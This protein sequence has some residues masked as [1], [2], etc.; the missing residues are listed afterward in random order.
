MINDPLVFAATS[1]LAG[2][3]RGKAFPKSETEKRKSRGV[4][5]VPTNALI[6]CFDTIA[7]TPFGSLGDLVLL[8][9][10]AT[11]KS[12]D[13]EDGTP[14]EH[15]VLGDITTPEGDA[16]MS[17]LLCRFIT[18]FLQVSSRMKRN[19]TRFLRF[20]FNF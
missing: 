2:K 7:E 9:D 20:D 10:M 15:F 12:I 19:P 14:A 5:W 8:P 3:M 6:T 1:D 17:Q 16:W 11:A 18:K 4:G 13:F